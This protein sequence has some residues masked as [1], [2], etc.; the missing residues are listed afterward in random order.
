MEAST[1]QI[2]IAR[3]FMS[4]TEHDG[5]EPPVQ[6]HILVKRAMNTETGQH[7]LVGIQPEEPTSSQEALPLENSPLT[8]EV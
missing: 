4:R 1:N 6:I 5:D 2:L 8:K 7:V 3:D